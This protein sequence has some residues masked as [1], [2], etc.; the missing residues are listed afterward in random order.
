M[1][2]LLLWAKWVVTHHPIVTFLVLLGLVWWYAK[3][4]RG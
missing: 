1:A 3:G 2:Y 4:V